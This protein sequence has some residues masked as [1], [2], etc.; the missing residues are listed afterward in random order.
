MGEHSLFVPFRNDADLIEEG[1][2]AEHAFNR[3]MANNSALN[4]QSEKL[5]KMLRVCKRLMRPGKQR[6]RM[7][8]MLIHS[9]NRPQQP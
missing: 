4:T 2:N 1:E 6:N 8:Q 9:R 7:L 3:H 5:Q